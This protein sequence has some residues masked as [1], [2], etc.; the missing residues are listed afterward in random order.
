MK[1][2]TICTPA[3]CSKSIG[4]SSFAHEV[5]SIIHFSP[6]SNIYL[7]I[8]NDWRAFF[9]TYDLAKNIYVYWEILMNKNIGMLS[10]SLSI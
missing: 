3:Q 10:N 9:M 2:T 8:E 1:P 5:K 7:M 4:G 6:F